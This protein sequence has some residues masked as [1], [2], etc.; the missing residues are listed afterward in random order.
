MDRAPPQ[1]ARSACSQLASSGRLS[2]ALLRAFGLACVVSGMLPAAASAQ[3]SPPAPP[4]RMTCVADVCTF[5]PA[6]P[7]PSAPAAPDTAAPQPLASVAR[8]AAIFG[9]VSAALTLSGS[10]AL[11]TMDSLHAERIGRGV[12]LGLSAASV[13]IIGISSLI[14]RRRTRVKGIPPLRN[15]FWGLWLGVLTTDSFFLY[16]AL[17]DEQISLAPSIVAGAVSAVTVLGFA[18]DAFICSREAR[19]KGFAFN[20]SGRGLSM[21][22][23]F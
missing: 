11:G 16:F 3:A 12:M 4:P 17:R 10:I 14:V 6:A 1:S 20:V 9:I 18:V 19:G 2:H 22:L 23:R 15:S 21:R 7:P 5:G 8:G 13:P